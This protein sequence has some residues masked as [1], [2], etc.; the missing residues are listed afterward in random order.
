MQVMICTAVVN[1]K[2]VNWPVFPFL[3]QHLGL[4]WILSLR[5]HQVHQAIPGHLGVPANEKLS[6]LEYHFLVLNG[7][8]K[9]Q[10]TNGIKQDTVSAVARHRKSRCKWKPSP[11]WLS[12]RLKVKLCY[13]FFKCNITRCHKL[14]CMYWSMQVWYTCT[15][16]LQ[17]LTRW[18]LSPQ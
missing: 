17:W 11:I 16:H 12:W 8:C 10:V 6:V 3:P 13:F 4:L 2:D 18:K 14:S 15:E 9:P 5:Q 1:N 7:T